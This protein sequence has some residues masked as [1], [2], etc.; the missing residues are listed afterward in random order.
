[1]E[2]MPF[3][4]IRVK[5]FRVLEEI[6]KLR[7]YHGAIRPFVR[8]I[9]LLLEGDS[10]GQTD[11]IFQFR[12]SKGILIQLT[13]EQQKQI[14]SFETIQSMIGEPDILAYDIYLD[15]R[16]IGFAMLR[17]YSKNGVF[18]WDYAIESKCQ[19]KGYGTE[20]LKCL[21]KFLKSTL[22]IKEIT[23]TYIWGNEHAKHI[24]EKV[25]FIETDVV[26]EDDIHEVNMVKYL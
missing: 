9:F 5:N 10:M 21:L 26:D 23:T 25:G 18:L 16:C 13:E 11:P 24:Y 17:M 15:S 1:M 14:S 6:L 4:L 2:E 19:N 7:W 20:A 12:E 3:R 8:T 22:D